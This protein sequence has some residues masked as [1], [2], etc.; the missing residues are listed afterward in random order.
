MS[1]NKTALNEKIVINGAIQL[2]DNLIKSREI[3]YK[4]NYE[5]K[6]IN[7]AVAFFT[8]ELI[9]SCT[10][11]D[12]KRIK[13]NF[14]F[15]RKNS[16]V[17]NSNGFSIDE[18]GLLKQA[19]EYGE[20]HLIGVL[21]EIG[22][23]PNHVTSDPVFTK[24]NLK[25]SH[26][27]EKEKDTLKILKILI[28]AGADLSIKGLNQRN[29]IAKY[30]ETNNPKVIEFLIKKGLDVNNQDDNLQTALM[31]AHPANIPTL[32]KH[33]AK[34][35]IQDKDGNTALIEHTAY[36][37]KEN[38]KLLLAA[39]A[40]TSIKN[41]FGK[42]ARMIVNKEIIKHEE[43]NEIETMLDIHFNKQS[44]DFKHQVYGATLEMNYIMK[45]Y[46]TEP[47]CHTEE[48]AIQHFAKTFA[49][50][51]L[52]KKEDPM[53]NGLDFYMNNQGKFEES[54][55]PMKKMHTHTPF[56]AKPFLEEAKK[57]KLKKTEN[58]LI[59][60]GCQPPLTLVINL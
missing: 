5:I 2:R 26:S 33:G 38:I 4:P 53:L 1:K 52:W 39:G 27:K 36:Y 37:E 49:Q 20:N 18:T 13:T 28:K 12:E 21:L 55:N 15:L 48:E 35:D 41:N 23:S 17:L 42:T 50:A 58:K 54:G 40:D 51:M 60:A 16:D 22:A 44:S 29:A 59:E 43:Y 30:A 3:E 14:R 9:D 31:N 11:N 8:D 24:V 25:I 46:K 10:Y 6:N 34:L 56:L 57:A 7:D 45:D 32:L 47:Q 19:V